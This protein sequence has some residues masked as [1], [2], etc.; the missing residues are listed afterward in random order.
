MTVPIT[1]DDNTAPKIVSVDTKPNSF[2]DGTYS[3]A[4][5]S[6][7]IDGYENGKIPLSIHLMRRY[8]QV[9]Q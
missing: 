5:G 8:T 9:L 3:A 7:P 2:P 1:F 4:G 6:Y